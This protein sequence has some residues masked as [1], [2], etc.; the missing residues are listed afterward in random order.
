MGTEEVRRLAESHPTGCGGVRPLVS[1]LET[2]ADCGTTVYSVLQANLAGSRHVTI[3]LHCSCC[4]HR[5]QLLSAAVGFHHS[6]TP[7]PCVCLLF[8]FFNLI[9]LLFYLFTSHPHS[10]PQSP[11]P[12]TIL[13]PPLLLGVGDTPHTHSFFDTRS[14]IADKIS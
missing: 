3:C 6:G 2:S 10:P 11:L 7:T 8:F 1:S 12:H 5:H 4:H 13:S 14:H 9:N